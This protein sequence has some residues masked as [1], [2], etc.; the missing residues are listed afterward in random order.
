MRVFEANADRI[1]LA[2][3]SEDLFDMYAAET[4]IAQIGGAKP[5]VDMYRQMEV[6]GLA[7]F[8]VAEIDSKLI[9]FCVC[10]ISEH[11][12]YS[13]TVATIDAIYVLPEHRSSMA[14]ARLIAT[15]KRKALE[16]GASLVFLSARHGSALHKQLERSRT[17]KPVQHIFAI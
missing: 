4:G 17:A 12:H 14:G 16:L 15:A 7:R 6:C 13:K 9:G 10:I 11:P 5:D 2:S 8:F 3:N 1:A